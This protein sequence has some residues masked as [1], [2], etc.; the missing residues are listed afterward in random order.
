M[1]LI[2]RVMSQSNIKMKIKKIEEKKIEEKKNRRRNKKLY[3]ANFTKKDFER[4]SKFNVN[5]Q[6][7]DCSH[8]L[9]HNDATQ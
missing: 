8:F 4:M 2:L 1:I 5:Y 3:F 7:I 6:F 9:K